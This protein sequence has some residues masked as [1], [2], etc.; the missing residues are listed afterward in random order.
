MDRTALSAAWDQVFGTPRP[1][2]LSSPFMRR[3]L[4]FRDAGPGAG[5]IA[6]GLC[7][8]AAEGGSRR[9]GHARSR[10]EARRVRLIRDWNGVT[11][12]VDVVGRAGSAGRARPIARSPP[13]AR[14]ITG[15]RWSGP[16]FFGLSGRPDHEHARIRCAI[17]TR[18]SSRRGSGSG[19]QLARCAVRGLCRLH[20]QPAP[21]RL[22]ARPRPLS[23]MAA[24]PAARWNAPPCSGCWPRSMPGASAWSWSTR[25][26]G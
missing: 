14:T 6:Q 24:C 15:A 9:P 19:L 13:I 12:V 25:S 7:R 16:R 18:K 21:R 4:A 20:R 22:E 26:T 11:H 1:E 3:Y 8:Q 17:Y 5:R 2:R 23:M 10:T